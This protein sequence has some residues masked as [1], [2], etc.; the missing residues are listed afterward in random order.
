MISGRLDVVFAADQG[1]EAATVNTLADGDYFGEI[2]LLRHIPRTATVRAV[3]ACKLLRID[4]EDFLEVIN[5]A[6]SISGTLL[7]G[8]SGRLARTHP[9]D[10]AIRESDD[11][12]STRTVGPE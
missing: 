8:V 10:Q 1:A 11:G 5:Q 12:P 9:S 2:G 4:G 7:R 6:P 3:S